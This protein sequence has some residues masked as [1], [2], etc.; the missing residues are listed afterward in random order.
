MDNYIDN[1]VKIF[2]SNAN[3][4]DAI[5]FE[6]YMRNQFQFIGIRS[7]R[8]KEISRPFLRRENLPD[9]DNTD[10]IVRQLWDLPEREFQYFAMDLVGKYVKKAEIDIITLLEHMV[11]NKSWWDTVDL[12]AGTQVGNYFKK[13]P[14]QII[15]CTEKWMAVDNFWLQ[16]TALLF[17]LKYKQSTDED[18]LYTY[19]KRLCHL[20]EFFIQKAIGWSLREYSKTNPLSVEQFVKANQAELA[21]LSKREALKIIVKNQKA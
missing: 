5:Q 18:L 3:R 16:R 15:P 14:Q 4:Q 20:K 17:Q 9:L 8:R 11:I 19:I 6:R 12:I 10:Q 1:L 2:R 21:P 13:Y 7:P